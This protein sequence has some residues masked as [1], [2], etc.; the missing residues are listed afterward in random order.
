LPQLVPYFDRLYNVIEVI[1]TNCYSKVNISTRTATDSN[2][3]TLGTLEPKVLK[4]ITEKTVDRTR[5]NCFYQS[6]H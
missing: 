2:N 6:Y 3:G 5:Y 1:Y 4:A